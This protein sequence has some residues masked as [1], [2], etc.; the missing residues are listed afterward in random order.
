MGQM[1]VGHRFPDFFKLRDRTQFDAVL[2]VEISQ[3]KAKLGQPVLDVRSNTTIAAVTEESHNITLACE[4][5]KE[6]LHPEPE[7]R[8]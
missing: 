8:Y 5:L 4:L 3:L 7:Q 1:F 6:C 2:N